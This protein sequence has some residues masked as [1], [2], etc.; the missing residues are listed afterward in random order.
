M[1]IKNK[2]FNLIL[3]GFI[4]TSLF[5]LILVLHYANPFPSDLINYLFHT[6][7]TIDSITVSRRDADPDR[8]YWVLPNRFP[9]YDIIIHGQHKVMEKLIIDS[10]KLETPQRK[11]LGFSHRSCIVIRYSSKV[12]HTPFILTSSTFLKDR[13]YL[14]DNYPA[15]IDS[16]FND[17]N[18]AVT[19]FTS[20][21][22]FHSIVDSYSAIPQQTLE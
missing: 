2:F 18:M 3:Y 14:L 19:I 10:L 1:N 8:L 21:G 7:C 11:I 5:Y 16:A 17:H 22:T 13:V 20:R 15:P 12:V 9:Q 6:N 4:I